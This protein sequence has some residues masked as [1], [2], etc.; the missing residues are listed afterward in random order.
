MNIVSITNLRQF[1]DMSAKQN[2]LRDGYVFKNSKTK[3][4]IY[5]PAPKI[6]ESEEAK[7]KKLSSIFAKMAAG[8]RLSHVEMEYLRENS[9]EWYE[10]AKQL[11]QE[12]EQY[13][14]ALENCKTKDQ[15]RILHTQKM[16]QVMASFKAAKASKSGDAM[17][18]VSMQA[19]TATDE[20]GDFV[21]SDKY[22]ELP[23]EYEL[24]EE[25]IEEQKERYENE[26]DEENEENEDEDDNENNEI[27]DNKNENKNED[28]NEFDFEEKAGFEFEDK[29]N[30]IKL[31]V[32]M[33]KKRKKSG[34][35]V[36][37]GK[38]DVDFKDIEITRRG[39]A[40][41][42]NKSSYSYFDNKKATGNYEKIS[43]DFEKSKSGASLNIPITLTA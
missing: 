24:V 20:F 37:I 38:T 1:I 3:K 6:R 25:L 22:E 41:K 32:E 19:A 2:S 12:R 5:V 31:D 43:V 39:E 11:E 34:K 27:S 40:K 16:A 13:R 7:G 36:Q 42:A 4:D 29:D 35:S 18:F 30:E 33:K 14:R 8:K 10:K 9:P 21:K 23:N 15:A 26:E 28:K 17:T